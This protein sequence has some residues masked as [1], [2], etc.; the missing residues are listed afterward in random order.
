MGPATTDRH[1]ALQI[2]ADLLRF[3]SLSFQANQDLVEHCR[4]LLLRNGFEIESL[5]DRRH[6][7]EKVNL[8]ARRGKGYGGFAFFG[9]IDVVPAD[10][11]TGPG[12]NP[13]EPVIENGRL[14]GRGSCD[15]KGPIACMLAAAARI[16]E[17]ELQ[18][19][20]YVI[21]TTD[22]EVGSEGAETVAAQSQLYR[23]MVQEHVA[24]VVGEPTRLH[25]VHGHKGTCL[26]RIVSHGRAGHSGMEGGRNANLAMIPF[27]MEMREIHAETESNPDW[28]DPRFSPPSLRWNIGINDRNDAV[29]ITSPQ[30]ICTVYFRP[31][32]GQDVSP[33]IARVQEAA[34]RY[35]LEF[36]LVRNSTPFFTT[37]HSPYIQKLLSFVPHSEA[38]T[39]TYGSDAAKLGDLR[40]LALLGPGDIAKAHT[41]EEW[42]SLADLEAGTDLYESLARYWCSDAAEPYHEDSHA[43][44]RSLE[45]GVPCSDP[46]NAGH[47]RSKAS[48]EPFAI[49]NAFPKEA[50]VLGPAFPQ[51]VF[52]IV[53]FLEPFSAARQILARTPEEVSR[54]VENGF[55][56]RVGEK[57][58]GF[59]AVEPYSRKLGELQSLAVDPG[60]R[61][62]G[63]GHRLVHLCIARARELRI[64]ELMAI[65]SSEQLFR[66]CGFEYSLPEQ[67]RALF[68]RPR[69]DADRIGGR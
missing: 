63:L 26:L 3:R 40:R 50:I 5:V 67:K 66:D 61:R 53:A 42:I 58:V 30:S 45:D 62:Q 17:S 24:A 32:P 35:G 20:L 33:L 28:L 52:A 16:S 18:R 22:E 60:Y 44:P 15:M 51:D 46:P 27:L 47:T 64:Y 48:F 38:T 37:P 69:E 4:E 21:L 49:Q 12:G 29:N 41:S 14:Y 59:A 65:T 34:E 56:A 19:P 57:I 1:P 39:V 68:I 6:E 55:V 9:H 43:V 10:D 8:V 25:V 36:T 54:L 13:F 23:Q 2:A 7:V 11:W 31:M